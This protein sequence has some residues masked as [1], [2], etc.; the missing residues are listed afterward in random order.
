[1]KKH[2]FLVLA[3][4]FAD[5][6]HAQLIVDSL[7]RVGVGTTDTLKSNHAQNNPNEQSVMDKY[8]PQGTRWTELRLDTM[9]YDSW[10]TETYV[11]GVRTWTP[12]F[13]EVLFYV[14]G[15]TVSVVG[16][17]YNMVWR[18][19][20]D[21]KHLHSFLLGEYVDNGRSVLTLSMFS[22]NSMFS[23]YCVY[24]FEDWKVG[25]ALEFDVF[26]W[27]H[28]MPGFFKP[29]KYGIIQELKTGNFGGT[30]DLEYVDVNS[31]WTGEAKLIRGIGVTQFN[32][33]DCLFGQSRCGSMEESYY[34]SW[35]GYNEEAKK[36][37]YRSILVHF[38]RD[39]E[40][41]Y[42]QWPTPGGGM[43]SHV[44]G[45]PT[46]GSKADGA[47]YDL[48]GRKVEGKSSRGIYI[49]GGRKRV[50]Q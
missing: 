25:K 21:V 19:T 36:I 32:A 44:Q 30:C 4:V 14:E 33:R 31:K 5:T 24:D 40:V 46:D 10:Y 43:A 37:D 18:D 35:E 42:D 6:A 16:E 13:E 15:D 20:K 3:L 7:G 2:L 50:M 28:L 41:L 39:G 1:M 12:N 27:W 47:V 29:Q 8:Y 9:K 45:V 38:E 22:L 23:P 49:I 17:H 11:D 26:A 48:Q 34:A